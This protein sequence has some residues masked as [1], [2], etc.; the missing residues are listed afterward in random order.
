MQSHTCTAMS[1]AGLTMVA[2][3]AIA[4]GPGFRVPRGPLCETCSSRYTR[5]DVRIRMPEGNSQKLGSI[6]Y[7]CY[8]ETLFVETKVIF[9][10]VWE[11]ASA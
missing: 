9:H 5:V 2:N 8:T 7:T 4:P 1:S 11:F 3:I 10:F 6:L